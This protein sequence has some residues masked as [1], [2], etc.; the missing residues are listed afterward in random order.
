MVR[1]AATPSAALVGPRLRSA[2]FVAPLALPVL[3]LWGV[4][5]FLIF[6]ITSTSSLLPSAL[7][8]VDGFALVGEILVFFGVLTPVALD[9]DARFLL[10]FFGVCG[11]I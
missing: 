11:T 5:G 4:L 9:T 6:E 1:P 7:I 10:P 3:E 8:S 2:D